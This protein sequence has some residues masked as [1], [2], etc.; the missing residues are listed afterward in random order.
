MAQVI[1]NVD[2]FIATRDVKDYIKVFLFHEDNMFAA[3]PTKVVKEAAH[4]YFQEENKHRTWVTKNHQ[5]F[6]KAP[7]DKINELYQVLQRENLQIIPW[8]DL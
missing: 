2:F 8:E 6:Y 7:D 1:E 4:I 3:R 5:G